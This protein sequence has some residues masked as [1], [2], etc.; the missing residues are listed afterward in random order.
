MVVLLWVRKR[1][2][3]RVEEALPWQLE[4]KAKQLSVAKLKS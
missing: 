1:N 4:K 3:R 2:N